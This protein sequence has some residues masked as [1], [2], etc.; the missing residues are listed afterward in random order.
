MDTELDRM[1]AIFWIARKRECE[2]RNSPAIII[3][4]DG[5]ASF[6]GGSTVGKQREKPFGDDAKL[7]RSEEGAE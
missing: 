1:I 5:D 3:S 7:R 4:I 2:V 6:A